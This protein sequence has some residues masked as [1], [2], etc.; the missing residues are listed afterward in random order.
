MK[1]SYRIV[2]QNKRIRYDVQIRR[3][4]TIIRGDSATGKTTLIDLIREYYEN[5]ESSGIALYCDQE[6]VV[7]GGRSWKSEM[8][9]FTEKLVFIDEGNNFV[10]TDEFAATLQQTNNYYI[11][12]TRES[13]PSLPYSVEE[14]YG[15]RE[16]GK[17]GTLKQTYNEFYHIYNLQ[18]YQYALSPHSVITEDS[19]SGYDFFHQ[20]CDQS[21]VFCISANGKSN[22]FAEVIKIEEAKQNDIILIIADGAAFGSEMDKLVQMMKWRKEIVLYLP[23]SFEWLILKSGVVDDKEIKDILASPA[24]YIESQNY[25]S[26]ERFFTALLVDKTKDTY[27]RYSK[28]RLNPAYYNEKICNKILAVMNQI[29]FAKMY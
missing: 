23:E 25:L 29:E 17:Y 24:D 26:W 1:G 10:F 14:V 7:L 19:N 28:K 21:G 11:I 8:L 3:N 9:S 27:L 15:I 12:V 6:C 4:I 16:S 2:V 13:I 20:L 18:E 22:I 5:G